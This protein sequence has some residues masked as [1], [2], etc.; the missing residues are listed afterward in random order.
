M[1]ARF[2]MAVWMLLRAEPALVVFVMLVVE[3]V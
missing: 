3:L 2:W 1:L